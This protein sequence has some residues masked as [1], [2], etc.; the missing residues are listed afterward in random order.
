MD[1]D[2]KQACSSIISLLLAIQRLPGS[3]Y[4]HCAIHKQIAGQRLALH[5]RNK[6]IHIHQVHPQIKRQHYQTNGKDNQQHY[7]FIAAQTPILSLYESKH[8]EETIKQLKTVYSKRNKTLEFILSN[9][10]T[11]FSS[12]TTETFLKIITVK[13]HIKIYKLHDS[14]NPAPNFIIEFK[15]K[16]F[17][18]TSRTSNGHKIYS[19]HQMQERRQVSTSIPWCQ[20]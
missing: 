8:S 1:Y 3:H 18:V 16:K 7:M 15:R 11:Y 17:T 19:I 2:N 12:E 5:T 10:M 6:H 13:R 9:R 20:Q 4:F 14:R